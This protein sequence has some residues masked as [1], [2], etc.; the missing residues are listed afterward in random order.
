MR[1]SYKTGAERGNALFIVLI[2]I[3]VLGLLTRMLASSS[4]QQTDGMSRE[5]RAMNIDRLLAHAAVLSSTVN[6]MIANGVDPSAVSTLKSGDAGF[7][8]S[9]HQAKIYHPLGG[10]IEYISSLDSATNFKVATAQ[11]ITGIGA[12]NALTTGAEILFIAQVSSAMCSSINTKLLG[13][14]T[15]PS[16]TDANFTIFIADSAAQV[17][18]AG[19]CAS[20]VNVAQQCIKNVSANTYAYYNTLYAR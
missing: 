7:T 16:M 2:A 13:S 20:C 15:V 4:E 14:S 17:I 8:T 19:N 5:M 9:P 12:S 10:G 18:N 1:P 11:T 3:I 6:Q